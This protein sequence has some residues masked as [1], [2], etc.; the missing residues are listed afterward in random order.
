MTDTLTLDS[1]KR[2]NVRRANS[3]GQPIG[4]IALMFR[5]CYSASRNLPDEFRIGRLVTNVG[6]SMQSGTYF[7]ICFDNFWSGVVRLESLVHR[8][9]GHNDNE[10]SNLVLKLHV[11][12]R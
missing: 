1:R 12:T 6:L 4:R 11:T 2:C 8:C 9:N 10:E 5:V 3:E 7:A